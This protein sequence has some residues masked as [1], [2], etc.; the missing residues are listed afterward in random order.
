VHHHIVST[1]WLSPTTTSSLAPD[2]SSW[3]MYLSSRS[4]NLLLL[5]LSSPNLHLLLDYSRLLLSL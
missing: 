2:T 4:S 5:H 1:L 3:V